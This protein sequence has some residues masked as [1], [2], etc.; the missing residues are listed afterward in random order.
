MPVVVGLIFH[1]PSALA[2][3][4]VSLLEKRHLVVEWHPCPRDTSHRVE[5]AMIVRAPVDDATVLRGEDDTVTLHG[6]LEA[7]VRSFRS[8]FPRI[9]IELT[10]SAT[11]E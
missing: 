1:G 7:D 4:F 2:W 11:S 3:V 5:V 6:Q 10:D 9:G 8:R